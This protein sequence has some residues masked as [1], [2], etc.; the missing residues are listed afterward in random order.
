MEIS[1]GYVSEPCRYCP[2]CNSPGPKANILINQSGHACLADFSLLT[3]A[4]DQSS[5]ISSCIGGGTIQWMSPELLIPERFG[6][7]RI[8]PTKESDC[9]ALGMVVYEVLSGHTPFA[10][11]KAPAVVS[12][13]LDGERPGRPQGEEGILFTDSIWRVLELCWEHWPCDRISAKAI[14]Q[15]L[16][17]NLSMLMPIPH[18]VEEDVETDTD[19]CS[20]T[21]ASESSMSLLFHPSLAFN[22]PYTMTGPPIAHIDNRSLDSLRMGNPKEGW[23]GDRLARSTGKIVRDTI[24]KLHRP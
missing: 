16:E 6:L 8:R 9:Y 19:A 17:G 13:V 1:K 24:R 21:T 14:L 11:S 2:A 23:I 12:K 22:Y 10:P 20:D 5:I 15:G 18:N 4:L 3:M 7:S